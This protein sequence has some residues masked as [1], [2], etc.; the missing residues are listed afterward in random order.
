VTVRDHEVVPRTWLSIQVE[1][2][3]G[4]GEVFWPRPGRTFAAARTHTFADMAAAIDDAFGRWDR[5]HLHQFWL[6]GNRRVTTPFEWDDI[7]DD[8]DEV[9]V[10]HDVKLGVLS[11]GDQFAYEFDFGDEWTHLCVVDNQRIDPLES[12]GIVPDKPLPFWGWGSLPDQYGRRW[13]Y[14]DG[15]S[16]PPVDNKGSDLPK[17]GPF[18]WRR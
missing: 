18:T 16:E 1:L 5:G 9:L 10:D 2:V 12:I 15:E 6:P 7:D 3:G 13:K 17:Y 8:G 14:D 4:R 11:L